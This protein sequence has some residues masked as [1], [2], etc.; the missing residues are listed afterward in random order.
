[1]R[2]VPYFSISQRSLSSRIIF[3]SFKIWWESPTKPSDTGTLGAEG[4]R[5]TRIFK[6]LSSFFCGYWFFYNNPLPCL[7][8]MLAMNSFLKMT[9][10]VAEVI[11]PV[12]T[13]ILCFFLPFF[14]LSR[15][16]F[17][18]FHLLKKT[19][20]SC[21]ALWCQFLLYSKVTQSY[22]YRHSFY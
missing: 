11:C 20:H 1:M 18:F 2:N 17:N 4:K 15:W 8:S 14:L 9:I 3:Y 6:Y 16:L 19:Y 5:G 12:S 22:M 10:W 13:V 21:F 7:V